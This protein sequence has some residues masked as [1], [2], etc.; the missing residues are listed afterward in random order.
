MKKENFSSVGTIITSILAT[1]CCIGPALFVLFGTSTGFLAGLTVFGPF[2]PYFLAA[3]AAMLGFSFW[4]LY[5]QEPDCRCTED[6]RARRIARIIFWIGTLFFLSALSI[7]R[8]LP[9]IYR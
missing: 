1:S 5:L 8:I 4:K 7:Q 9:L 3:A 6:I 2:R